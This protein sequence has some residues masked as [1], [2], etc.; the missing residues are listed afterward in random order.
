MK[1]QCKK[2]SFNDFDQMYSNCSPNKAKQ[3]GGNCMSGKIQ[4]LWGKMCAKY[5]QTVQKSMKN[6]KV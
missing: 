2:N 5:E 4:K 6:I 3:K 1:N